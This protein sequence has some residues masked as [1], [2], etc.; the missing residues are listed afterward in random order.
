MKRRRVISPQ[1]LGQQ[2]PLL[3][4]AHLQVAAGLTNPRPRPGCC[5]VARC[6]RRQRFWAEQCCD[7]RGPAA[8]L[9]EPGNVLG[10]SQRCPTKLGERAL[11]TPGLD[12]G[13]VKAENGGGDRQPLSSGGVRAPHALAP[14][15]QMVE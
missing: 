1:L 13:R 7:I 12:H 2:H 11:C 14:L 6:S 3:R 15:H 10:R 9:R 4:P 8:V 5:R